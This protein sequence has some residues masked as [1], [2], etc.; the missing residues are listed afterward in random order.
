MTSIMS[1]AVRNQDLLSGIL[2]KSLE[3]TLMHTFDPAIPGRATEGWPI[4]GVWAAGKASRFLA[5]CGTGAR[6]GC[7]GRTAVMLRKI[8]TFS[9][10]VPLAVF[11][12]GICLSIT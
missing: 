10:A 9:V 1:I 8:R 11:G 2:V 6:T 3:M 7:L 12:G 4:L 5:T